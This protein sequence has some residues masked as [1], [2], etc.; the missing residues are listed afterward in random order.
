MTPSWSNIA[1]CLQG[2]QFDILLCNAYNVYYSPLQMKYKTALVHLGSVIEAT[3]Q[4]MLLMVEGDPR[5][6]K[7]LGT[8]WVWS[9]F[10]TVPTPG[11]EVP[12]GLRA[13]AGTQRQ[14]RNTVN[15]NT[16]LQTTYRGC[17]R[18][19]DP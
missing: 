13:V 9:D 4:Y 1:G 5:V 11:I 7:A 8:Y 15:R 10:N 16:K 17:R 3:L 12:D 2:I 6:T 14:V 18:G 19:R